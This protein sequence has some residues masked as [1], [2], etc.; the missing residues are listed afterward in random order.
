MVQVSPVTQIGSDER[1]S[2]H[3][4]N[5][6][7]EGELM[8]TYRRQGS[9]SGRHYHTGRSPR[10][11]PEKLVLMQGRA[12]INWRNMKGG[13]QG[14]V[15]V[16]APALISI[17]PWAWHKVMADTDIV[18]LELNSLADGRG[19]TFDAAGKQLY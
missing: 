17:E 19:D 2:T 1:G 16:E 12:T 5:S 13:E 10:K 8:I 18:T 11:N 14:S 9:A 4:F 7:R 6:D 3:V 15:T